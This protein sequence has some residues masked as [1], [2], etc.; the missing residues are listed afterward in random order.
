MRTA[1][2]IVVM[3]LPHLAAAASM[4]FAV[5]S[6]G[7]RGFFTLPA[8][9]VLPPG[10]FSIAS[11]LTAGYAGRVRVGPGPLAVGFGLPPA[12]EGTLSLRDNGLPRDRHHDVGILRVGLKLQINK[13]QERSPSFA[14]AVS[15]DHLASTLV[16]SA[17]VIVGSW[18]FGPWQAATMAG[19]HGGRGRMKAGPEGGV[20]LAFRPS[21]K[22]EY[23]GEAALEGSR[24][25]ALQVS[26]AARYFVL[27]SISLTAGLR[28]GITGPAG[29]RAV[30][31]LALHSV[32]ETAPKPPQEEEK[33]PPVR[34][35]TERPRFRLR[36]PLR[37]LP[38][39][40]HYT[41][42][43]PEWSPEPAAGDLEHN[44]RQEPQDKGESPNEENPEE[45]STP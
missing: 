18:R 45:E 4:D 24:V 21:K 41:P 5:D 1:C 9:D 2:C 26:A 22:A 14:V 30:V 23:L 37:S 34:F 25:W 33:T 16:P 15:V 35:S 17:R 43:Q 20:A 42:L 3:L 6:T 36:V 38:S 39:D 27:P 13:A 10:A 40:H 8:P 31:G 11:E 19:Y 28:W 29:I 32:V 44:L 7:G 12:L